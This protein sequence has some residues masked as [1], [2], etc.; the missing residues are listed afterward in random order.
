MAEMVTNLLDT[1]LRDFRS[2]RAVAAAVRGDVV[3]A[4][5]DRA[6][7][8]TVAFGPDRIEVRDGATPGVPR[9]VAPWLTMAGVC[10]GTESPLRAWRRG[11]LTISPGRHP[12]RVLGSACALSVPAS[13]YRAAEA[14][15]GGPAQGP[16]RSRA[17][18]WPGAVALAVVVIVVMAGARKHRRARH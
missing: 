8:V 17:M 10:A 16:D 2:R 4:V 11:E 7:A 5:A 14:P 15:A 6:A 1:N 13:F 18:A 9:V 3:L 12:A